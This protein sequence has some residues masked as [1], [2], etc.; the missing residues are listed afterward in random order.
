MT[1]LAYDVG[2]AI[3]LINWSPDRAFSLAGQGGTILK[4]DIKIKDSPKWEFPN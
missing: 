4:E 3:V 2:P 1:Y